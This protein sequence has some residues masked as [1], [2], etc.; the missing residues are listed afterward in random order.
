MKIHFFNHS[1]KY[2]FITKFNLIFI[3]SRNIYFKLYYKS[4]T[5]TRFNI[6]KFS[7][8]SKKI[9]RTFTVTFYETVKFV[10]NM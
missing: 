8:H 3:I 4:L 5:Y 9:D 7:N 6:L 2:C 10:V 1:F